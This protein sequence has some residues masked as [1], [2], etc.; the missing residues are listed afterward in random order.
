M[1][2]SPLKGELSWSI[3]GANLL[4]CAPEEFATPRPPK[5]GVVLGHR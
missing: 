5:G 4:T 1:P 3:A 2:P